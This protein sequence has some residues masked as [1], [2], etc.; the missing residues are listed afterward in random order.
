MGLEGFLISGKPFAVY[1]CDLL[2]RRIFGGIRRRAKALPDPAARACSRCK[3]Q[4][5]GSTHEMDSL[6]G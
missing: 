6:P 4:Q 2:F 5:T 3:A 1:K